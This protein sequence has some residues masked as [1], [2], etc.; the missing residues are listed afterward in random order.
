LGYA[1]ITG[2]RSFNDDTK[3][4]TKYKRKEEKIGPVK[5]GDGSQPEGDPEWL[6][7][8]LAEERPTETPSPYDKWLV[9]KFSNIER[10]SRLTKER[11]EAMKIPE[12]LRPKE[13]ELLTEMM[14]KREKV[15]AWTV[16]EKGMV[17]DEVEPPHQVRTVDHTP[18]AEP[19]FRLPRKL[20]EIEREHV[21]NKLEVKLFE[22]CWGPYRNASFFVPKK[23]PGKYRF[24]ISCTKANAVTK[25]DAGLSPNV[26]EYSE[27]FSG[28][29]AVTYRFFGL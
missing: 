10:G 11:L 24:I 3:I 28:Y 17:R 13:K 6:M 22:P 12:T 1:L 4:L 23:S 19:T 21:R 2:V 8:I 5:A 16:H 27:G 14:F 9:P 20:I 7:K 15:F 26:D 25:Q 18:W 29:P